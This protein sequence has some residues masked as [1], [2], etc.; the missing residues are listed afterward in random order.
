MFFLKSPL[1]MVGG[2]LSF[3]PLRDQIKRAYLYA[4]NA[5]GYGNEHEHP[6]RALEKIENQ[7]IGK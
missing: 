4:Y 1:G 7:Q 6:V 5:E 3:V 2:D